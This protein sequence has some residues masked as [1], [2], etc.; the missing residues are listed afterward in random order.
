MTWEHAQAA[1]AFLWQQHPLHLA[2]LLGD[3]VRLAPLPLGA[4][5]TGERM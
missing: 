5:H 1:V 3:L 4:R 2:E